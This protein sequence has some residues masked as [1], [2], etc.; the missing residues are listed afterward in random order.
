MWLVTQV[1]IIIT[2]DHGMTPILDSIKLRNYNITDKDIRIVES[3]PILQA[4]FSN[5]A[6]EQFVWNKLEQVKLWTLYRKNNIPDRLH[7]RD[8]PRIPPILAIANEGYQIVCFT[9]DLSVRI[10]LQK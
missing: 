8:N 2:A 1:N 4:Y 6:N 7:F 3:G 9:N 10:L 5:G